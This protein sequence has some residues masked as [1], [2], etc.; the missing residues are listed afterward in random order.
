MI[1]YNKSMQTDTYGQS[2]NNS[3]YYKPTSYT[4]HSLDI[5]NI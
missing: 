3:T 4:C 1:I 2:H 5:S